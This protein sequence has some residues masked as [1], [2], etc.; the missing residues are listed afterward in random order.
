MTQL[1]VLSD[2]TSLW[3]LVQD[4]SGKPAILIPMPTAAS[5]SRRC[6][7]ERKHGLRLAARALAD[8]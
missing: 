1:V 6:A 3:Q 4:P 5:S 7:A 8:E 2:D